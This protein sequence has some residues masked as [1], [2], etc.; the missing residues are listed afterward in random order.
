[1]YICCNRHGLMKMK[2]P[3]TRRKSSI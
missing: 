3:T 2:I 1:L